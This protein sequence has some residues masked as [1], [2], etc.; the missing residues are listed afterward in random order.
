MMCMQHYVLAVAWTI[1]LIP[2]LRIAQ[3]LKRQARYNCFGLDQGSIQQ[4]ELY[5][6]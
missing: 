2:V 4:N 1:E 5:C 3:L 6:L